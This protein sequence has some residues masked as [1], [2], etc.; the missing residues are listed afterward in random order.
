MPSH[1][2]PILV[3][4]YFRPLLPP[5]ASFHSH[6]S[7][8]LVY[9]F[10]VRNSCPLPVKWRTPASSTTH[11]SGF[12]PSGPDQLANVLP[13]KSEVHSPP[14]R[15]GRDCRETCEQKKGGV[16]FL[17]RPPLDEAN[18]RR[19]RPRCSAGVAARQ[20]RTRVDQ[21][22][23]VGNEKAVEPVARARKASRQ[24]PNLLEES[25]T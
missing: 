11:P 16:S 12:A 13:S 24:R 22:F 7:S 1:S 23:E 4:Q 17:H 6:S 8:K 21:V 15:S 3:T 20:T 10:S 25:K 14:A 2:L 19:H 18:R 5:A 9:S